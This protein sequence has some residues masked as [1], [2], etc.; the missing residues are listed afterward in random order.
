MSRLSSLKYF[1][2]SVNARL[3]VICYRATVIIVGR[4]KAINE[5]SNRAREWRRRSSEERKK[6]KVKRGL[7]EENRRGKERERR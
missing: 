4:W 1:A 5:R 7:A 3:N 6:G 2:S